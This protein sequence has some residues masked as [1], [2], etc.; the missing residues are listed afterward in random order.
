MI[1]LLIFENK[2]I[3]I[4]STNANVIKLIHSTIHYFC[5]FVVLES[6]SLNFCYW[7]RTLGAKIFSVIIPFI[8]YIIIQPVISVI[9]IKYSKLGVVSL[10]ISCIVGEVF[11]LICL[12]IY[13]IFFFDIEKSC[14]DVFNQN[15][16]LYDDFNK[17]YG[18]I[19]QDDNTETSQHQ[20]QPI[21]IKNE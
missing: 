4:I 7:F 13:L 8:Q 5:I 14:I 21:N 19:N 1:F 12:T 18:R 20:T 16:K 3:K 9:L 10:W 15:Q 11:T 2:L 6:C 17:E